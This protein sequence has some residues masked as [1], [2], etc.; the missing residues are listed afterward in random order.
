[1]H[2]QSGAPQ[3]ICTRQRWRDVEEVLDSWLVETEWWRPTPIRRRYFH[4]LL[5]DGVNF[6][7][8]RDLVDEQWYAQAA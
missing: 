6:T 1:L 2:A 5:A 8:F 7:L 3:R 4:L